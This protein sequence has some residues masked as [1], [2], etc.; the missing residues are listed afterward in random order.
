TRP[1]P[2]CAR[3]SPPSPWTES[4]LRSRRC[5]WRPA[6]SPTWPTCC[7][8]AT[9]PTTGSRVSARRAVARARSPPPTAVSRA[10]SAP[11]V[12]ATS[13]RGRRDLGGSCLKVRGVA[14]L[15]GPRR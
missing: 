14:P 12:S 2:P 8:W 6:T 7:C 3:S 13:A 4:C 5:V 1:S 11:S 10:P 15:R 9:R